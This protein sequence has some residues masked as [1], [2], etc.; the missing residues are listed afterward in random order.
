MR[1]S[2]TPSAR[3]PRNR[4]AWRVVVNSTTSRGLS[5]NVGEQ[6]GGER[7]S[8]TDIV[9]GEQGFLQQVPADAAA[10]RL[11][12]DKK[13]PA[14]DRSH[15]LAAAHHI[16]AA[17][18]QNCDCAISR[19]K[20]AFQRDQRVALD[21][22][23][24]EGQNGLELPPVGADIASSQSKQRRR[25]RLRGRG[26]SRP[27]RR[28]GA[29]PRR[30]WPARRSGRYGYWRRRSWRGREILPSSVATAARQLVPPPS[31]PRTRST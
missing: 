2:R 19:A 13:P 25:L 17:G 8:R 14:A 28:P 24:G 23:S 5:R 18:A 29:M 7:R 11:V 22:A 21:N 1:H 4:R 3:N 26:R 27:P 15:H 9:V 12:A 16:G 30:C 6:R 10:A 20:G 31:M